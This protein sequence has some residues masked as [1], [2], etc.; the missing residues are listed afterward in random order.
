MLLREL[1]REWQTNLDKALAHD[2]EFGAQGGHEC[3]SGKAAPN[4][5]LPRR[6]LAITLAYA[7]IS[8]NT[9]TKFPPITFSVTR[10]E[11]PRLSS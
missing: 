5:I 10:S 9:R 6:H 7:Q 4:P 3:L 11:Y 2:C 1:R 8:P